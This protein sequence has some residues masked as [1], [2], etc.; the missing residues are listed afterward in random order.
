MTDCVYTYITRG[1]FIAGTIAVLCFDRFSTSIIPTI[2]LVGAVLVS[3][4]AY[5]IFRIKPR[6]EDGCPV[7][8]QVEEVS[9]TAV[10]TATG[11]AGELAGFSQMSG[12]ELDK[13]NDELLA[14]LKEVRE[15]R[16]E[17]M[18][19]KLGY[20]EAASK[21]SGPGAYYVSLQSE[22]ETSFAAPIVSKATRIYYAHYDQRTGFLQYSEPEMPSWKKAV[23]I[24]KL[25][26]PEYQ[27]KL[28]PEGAIE[29]SGGPPVGFTHTK[30][31][32]E[33]QTSSFKAEDQWGA[34][35]ILVQ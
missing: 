3:G 8:E 18:R 31:T 30:T 19:K 2:V 15:A 25:L 17:N 6:A 34:P 1:C 33:K 27:V 13:V 23:E 11:K 35:S 28:T 32:H 26:A 10:E 22:S 29:I 21:S 24:K 9:P 16:L 5:L 14:R 12:A 20:S 7:E 4:C